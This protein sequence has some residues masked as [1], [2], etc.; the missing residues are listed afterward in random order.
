MLHLERYKLTRLHLALS[1]TRERKLPPKQIQT[2]N[3]ENDQFTFASCT[4]LSFNKAFL[5]AG[6]S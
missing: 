6:E 1:Y 5:N 4:N 3:A 2:R